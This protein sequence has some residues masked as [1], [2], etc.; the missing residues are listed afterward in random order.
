MTSLQVTSKTGEK[1]ILKGLLL[2]GISGEKRKIEY[3]LSIS[4]GIIKEKED[5]YKILSAE[6]LDKFKK[7]TIEENDDTFQWWAELKLT[8]QLKKQLETL[9]GIEI[10]QQ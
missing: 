1:E 4:A 8:D 5:S 9:S 2:D 3:A 10:C 7:G 6:F